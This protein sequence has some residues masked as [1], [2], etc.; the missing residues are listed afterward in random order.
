MGRAGKLLTATTTTA[1]PAGPG[2]ARESSP[3]GAAPSASARP[4]TNVS[5]ARSP[6]ERR[7]LPPSRH[8]SDGKSPSPLSSRRIHSRSQAHPRRPRPAVPCHATRAS[9]PAPATAARTSRASRPPAAAARPALPRLPLVGA[10]RARAQHAPRGPFRWGRGERRGGANESAEGAGPDVGR[11]PGSDATVNSRAGHTAR[12]WARGGGRVGRRQVSAGRAGGLGQAAPGESAPG[13]PSGGTVREA[14]GAEGAA[15]TGL[16]GGLPGR[17]S[18]RRFT[19]RPASPAGRPGVCRNARRV[20]GL[21]L[22]RA[23]AFLLHPAGTEVGA[24]R[25]LGGTEPEL[26]V[27]LEGKINEAGGLRKNKRMPLPSASA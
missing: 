13:D 18:L 1:V 22:L 6:A 17:N 27:A 16:R 14:A 21:L 26:C 4:L 19:G 2:T 15:G 24:A 7:C 25:C 3:R 12:R 9:H 20:G 5:S 10:R 11:R 23:A 8:G